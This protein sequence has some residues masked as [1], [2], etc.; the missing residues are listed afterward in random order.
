MG[1]QTGCVVWKVVRYSE[2]IIEFG[3]RMEA[4]RVELPLL[5]LG[6]ETWSYS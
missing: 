4:L 2:N 1:L 3:F 6:Y 5:L